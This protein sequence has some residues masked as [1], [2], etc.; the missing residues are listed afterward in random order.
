MRNDLAAIAPEDFHRRSVAVCRALVEQPEYA[1]AQVVMIYLSMPHEADTSHIALQCWADGKRVLA[2]RVSWEQRRMLPT[3]IRS[4]DSDV[5]D[6]PMGIPEPME[7][8]PIPVGDID[9]II[10]PGLAF[11]KAGMRLG[12]G[13]GFYDRFLGHRDFRA[14][15]C[16]IALEAQVVEK[17]PIEENDKRLRM[18]VTNECVRRFRPKPR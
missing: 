3:E 14:F 18:L 9:L 11:D 12:R 17:V 5:H 2:P 7:G 13:R 1:R 15:S 16:G 8:M 4:L 6:G 10:V